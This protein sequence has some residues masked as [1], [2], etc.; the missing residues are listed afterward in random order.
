[1][2]RR[3]Q[4]ISCK[5]SF[6]RSIKEN[7][8]RATFSWRLIR[9]AWSIPL[10][11]TL[12]H[13]FWKKLRDI[14]CY[15]NTHY[16]INIH[17][18]TSVCTC[19]YAH[20]YNQIYEIYKYIYKYK[21]I[22]TLYMKKSICITTPAPT[23]RAGMAGCIWF[24]WCRRRLSLWRVWRLLRNLSLRRRSF[25]SL[26]FCWR[27]RLLWSSRFFDR[28]RV[29]WQLQKKQKCQLFKIFNLVGCIMEKHQMPFRYM[30]DIYIYR[31]T[32]EQKHY[33]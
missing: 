33:T 26:I 30:K 20:E 23:G 18:S 2:R 9:S 3:S 19:P 27:R 15:I 14:K 32:R 28:R 29:C 7:Y 8:V 24:I 12:L 10:R 11:R 4:V 6:S 22:K 13:A 31:N 17:A 1:M 25:F 16:C 21:W 5:I